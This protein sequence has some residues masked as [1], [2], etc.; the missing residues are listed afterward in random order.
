MIQATPILRQLYPP[1][2]SKKGDSSITW[3]KFPGG[4]LSLGGANTPNSFSM[5]SAGVVVGDDIDRFPD[6][7]GHGDD[8]EGKP[9]ELLIRRTESY[10]ADGRVLLM[11]TPTTEIGSTIYE[12]YQ[13]GTQE[14]F[15][16][17]CPGCSKDVVFG[18]HEP[19]TEYEAKTPGFGKVTFAHFYYKDKEAAMEA[20]AEKGL[21]GK[22]A[23]DAG[24]VYFVCGHCEHK[25]R[26]TDRQRML[27]AGKWV[28]TSDKPQ[29]RNRSF[30]LWRAYNPMTDWEEI[31][32]DWRKQSDR[33]DMEGL[34]T[35][36]NTTVGVPFKTD[37]VEDV[38]DKHPAKE[39]KQEEVPDDIL[40][41][42]AGMDVQ[43]K[44]LHAS[45]VGWWVEGKDTKHY[46]A[47]VLQ[48]IICEGSTDSQAVWKEMEEHLDSE[49][50]L[51]DG[52]SLPIFSIGVDVGDGTRMDTIMDALAE[53]QGKDSKWL[54]VKGTHSYKNSAYI[55]RI[56]K[57]NDDPRKEYP[58][59]LFQA[60]VNEIK[61]EMKEMQKSDRIHFASTMTKKYFEEIDSEVLQK[62]VVMGRRKSMWTKRSQSRPNEALDCLVYSRFMLYVHDMERKHWEQL[63]RERDQA[64]LKLGVAVREKDR[65]EEEP[66]IVFW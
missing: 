21:K 41:I 50:V 63:A 36:W 10:G 22:E 60:N 42:T 54:A 19:N 16:L 43:H 55:G 52:R 12:N 66:Q 48:H 14:V 47:Y 24:E 6:L 13:A 44:S 53:R 7:V 25:I 5:L 11:S 37:E 34:R 58:V 49:F 26:I 20:A 9:V 45:V 18:F 57:E 61:T 51:P 27:A 46:H 59:D 38:A 2:L 33:G 28:V 32:F 30:W 23:Q 64:R 56:D 4:Y 39:L 15:A 31:Y 40:I 62:R 65:K 1:P 3:R 29:V 8:V 35:F 17:P